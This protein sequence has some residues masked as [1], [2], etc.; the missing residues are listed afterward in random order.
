VKRIESAVLMAIAAVG[1]SA[2]ATGS[3][4][5]D[6]FR[7]IRKAPLTVPPDYNLRPPAPGQSRPQE[8]APDQTARAA[9][10]GT[11]IGRTASEGE[12][13][14]IRQAGGEAVEVNIRQE[15]DFDSAQVVRKPRSFTDSIL[16][17]GRSRDGEPALDPAAE[18]ERIKALKAGDNDLTG[19]GDVLIRRKA[20][21]KLP[22][23]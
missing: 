23:L 22:G 5:P 9:V 15:V 8:L 14:L 18:A 21:S 4:T 7:V 2:C 1:L 16:N 10:F 12:K 20:S 11:D 13:L 17:F 19:G 3:N 6:E